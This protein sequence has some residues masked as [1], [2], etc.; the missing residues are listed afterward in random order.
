VT[1]DQGTTALVR[2]PTPGPIGVDGGYRGPS[3]RSSPPG[4]HGL[5][6]DAAVESVED[7]TKAVADFRRSE[8]WFSLQPIAF[9]LLGQYSFGLG[10]LYGIGENVV[11]SVIELL[12]LVKMLLLADLYDRAQQPVF[13][14]ASLNPVA[15]LQRLMAEASM[16][17][18]SAELEEAHR[19]RNALIEELRYA[20]THIG[21]VL[22]NIGEGYVAKWNRFETYVKDRTLS[23]Q[24]HAGRMFGE[25]LI[26]V[27]SVIGG[28]AAAVKAA[29]KIPKL[30]KLA[31][32]RIPPR[33]TAVSARPAAG[34]AASNVA[35]TPAQVHPVLP[36]ADAAAQ[37]PSL[38]AVTRTP[39]GQ[40]PPPPTYIAPDVIKAH[41][42]RFESGAVKV[43]PQAPQGVI[44]PPQGTFVLPKS[45]V[46]QAITDSGG[47]VRKLEQLLGVD[48]GYLG[49]NPVLVEVAKP[50]GLRMPSGNEP[51]ANLRW[52]AG[53]YTSGG[54]PEAVVDQIQAGTYTVRPVF[55]R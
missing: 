46:A 6:S 22:G 4:A 31:R 30:A 32:L 37:S 48:K 44:G 34:A 15:L 29:G 24:F 3:G 27:V 7:L 35:M 28:G 45:Y 8:T 33:S 5:L 41:L 39:K 13:S 26:D 49:D 1:I 51:G 2:T 19:E 52:T 47:D 10:V 36:V 21:E 25:V 9:R 55:P 53:G 20:M 54:V 14:T 18:F 12:Q 43:M 40:R 17:T 16:R 50:T 42:T 23:S 11:T 38:A